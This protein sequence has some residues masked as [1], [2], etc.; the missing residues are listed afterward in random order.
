MEKKHII[1]LVHSNPKDITMLYNTN[2]DA[3]LNFGYRRKKH[4]FVTYKTHSTLALEA[5]VKVYV[6]RYE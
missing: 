2:R 6:M 1:S 5:R 4:Y 3:F